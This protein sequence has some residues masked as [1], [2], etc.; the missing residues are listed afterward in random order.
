MPR[1][2]ERER[3]AERSANAIRAVRRR[4]VER[5]IL[6]GAEPPLKPAC[7]PRQAFEAATAAAAQEAAI[8]AAEADL[9]PR[10]LWERHRAAAAAAAIAAEQAGVARSPSQRSPSQ[11]SPSQRSPSQRVRA[12][13]AAAKADELLSRRRP[14]PERPTHSGDFHFEEG[15]LKRGDARSNG[16]SPAR[17]PPGKAAP[18]ST[19]KRA[20]SLS[21]RGFAY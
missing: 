4:A 14:S 2:R 5:G 7:S 13:E 1:A 18:A 9:P 21:P 16:G 12:A 15:G 19:I 11:R 3:A 20:W 6:L 17:S 8:A 10:A